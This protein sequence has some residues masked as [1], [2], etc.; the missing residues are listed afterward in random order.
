M[1]CVGI[2][3]FRCNASKGSFATKKVLNSFGG[4]P[5]GAF[6][7]AGLIDLS[8]TLYGTTE[9]GGVGSIAG[10]GTVFSLKP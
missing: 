9:F 3:R 8:G 2:R 10:N 7:T 4:K 1:G 6:P 5:E